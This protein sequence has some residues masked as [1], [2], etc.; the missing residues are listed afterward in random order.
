VGGSISSVDGSCAA[1]EVLGG[2]DHDE[3]VFAAVAADED[4]DEGYDEECMVLNAAP[5][6]GSMK[7]ARDGARDGANEGSDSA[8]ASHKRLPR[9]AARGSSWTAAAA[10]GACEEEAMMLKMA[11]EASV[12][13]AQAVRAARLQRRREADGEAKRATKRAKEAGALNEC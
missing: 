4:V 10:A 13:E 2:M 11:L 6:S 12:A 8:R 1:G 3:S 5:V 7:R 9:R